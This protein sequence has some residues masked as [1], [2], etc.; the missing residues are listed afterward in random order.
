MIKKR[1]SYNRCIAH[2]MNE[3]MKSNLLVEYTSNALEDGN[4]KTDAI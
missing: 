1:L 4:H 3:Y 2:K